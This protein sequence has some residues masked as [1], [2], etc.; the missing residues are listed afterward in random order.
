M[1]RIVNR[2][3]GRFGPGTDDHNTA[4]S[5]KATGCRG[6]RLAL[7]PRQAQRFRNHAHDN[8]VGALVIEPLDLSFE[9]GKINRVISVVGG[10][11]NR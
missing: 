4:F 10:L 7:F 1:A 11:E 9:R 8:A 2:G 6:Q 3:V 5:P